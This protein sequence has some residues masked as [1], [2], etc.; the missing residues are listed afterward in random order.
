MANDLS[1]SISD[2]DHYRGRLDAPMQL[3]VYG[4]YECP[5]TQRALA[6]I[7]TVREQ[8]GD[9]V[10]FVFRNFPLIEIHRH[11]L[12]AA[13]AAEA[14]A[15]QDRF[16]EMHDRLF[17]HQRELTDTDLL[18]HARQL[19]LDAARFAEDRASEPVFRKIAEDVATGESSGVQGT[20]TLFVNG[21]FHQGSYEAPALIG[22]Y[23]S[24][25]VSP[26]GRKLSE[27]EAG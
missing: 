1:E 14:A 6:Q 12:H 5:Y 8:L 26:A 11:A 21:R 18:E 4:D 24:L 9:E 20:P 22:A 17:D 2:K 25:G 10:L 15:R 27:P 19:N 3:V 7:R 23:R 16:W 13:E